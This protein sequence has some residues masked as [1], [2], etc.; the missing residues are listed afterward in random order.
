MSMVRLGSF[1]GS[2]IEDERARVAF[3][4]QFAEAFIRHCWS[5]REEACALLISLGDAGE[6]DIFGWDD[7]PLALA[8]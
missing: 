1:F 7:A 8:G 3:R 6:D 5:M 2:R 4:S